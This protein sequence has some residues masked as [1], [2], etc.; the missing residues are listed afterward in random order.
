MKIY[1]PRCLSVP[2]SAVAL[3]LG[4]VV[5]PASHAQ[6]ILSTGATGASGASGSVGTNATI[7]PP[8]QPH[9]VTGGTGGAG[10]VGA[11]ALDLAGGYLITAGTYTGG[12]GGAGGRGG[13]GSPGAIQLGVYLLPGNG[14][15]GGVGGEGA[16]AVVARSGAAIVIAGGV[17]HAGSGGVGGAGGAG[18]QG[19]HS[20]G[21]GGPNQP[22][23]SPGVTGVAGASGYTLVATGGAIVLRGIF[24]GGP[25]VLASGTGAFTGTLVNETVAQTFTCSIQAGS[26][27]LDS[28]LSVAQSWRQQYFGTTAN[29][30]QAAD[31][32]DPDG[33]GISNL[34]ERTLGLDPRQADLAGLPV[35][36][37]DAAT[38]R[39]TLTAAKGAYS[40]DVAFSAEA[41]TDLV[42]WSTLD[43]TVLAD[44]A[45][46]FQ[47]RD[48][49]PANNG[50]RFLRLRVT[51]P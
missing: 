2:T 8:P 20:T 19:A 4:L 51:A 3:L 40:A 44:T 23:G 50:S 45:T 11:A 9:A 25:R 12:A 1:L 24:T 37:P 36:A 28:T 7:S 30:G 31:S 39:L 49:G 27:T 6:T 26:I 21:V 17:F 18:G 10:G 35:V 13:T 38:G 47:A 42:N 5:L 16:A 34:L 14:G 32:A 46:T 48:D 29:T 41:S 15:T 22:D 43:V 33:D